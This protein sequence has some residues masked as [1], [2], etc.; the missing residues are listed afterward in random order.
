MDSIMAFVASFPIFTVATGLIFLI[1]WVYAFFIVYHLTRFGI[2]PVP[3][4]FALVF[5]FGAL[6]LFSLTLLAYSRIDTVEIFS[7]IMRAAFGFSTGG[8]QNYLRLPEIVLPSLSPL[9]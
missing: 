8:L 2:G 4:L 1:Y 3:K 5:L 9:P 7:A 6:M